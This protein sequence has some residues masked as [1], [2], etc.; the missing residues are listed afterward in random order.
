MK[1]HLVSGALLLCLAA[2]AAHGQPPPQ[3]GVREDLLASYDG[4][5]RRL[6]R[7]AEAMPAER[8]GWRPADGVRSFSE[9]LMHVAEGNY[10][11]AKSLG[12]PGAETPEPGALGKVATK[13]EAVAK[14]RESTELARAAI[15]AIDPATLDQPAEF[16]GMTQSKRRLVLLVAEHAHEHLGQAIAYARV[17]GVAP[18]WSSG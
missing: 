11:F 18:P 1:R 3:P 9:V 16:F 10:H 7:L 13:T 6:L 17:N 14:L 8:F 2:A 5:T 4:A 15:T 12:V